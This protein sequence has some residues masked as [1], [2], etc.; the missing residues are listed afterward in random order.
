MNLLKIQTLMVTNKVS[1]LGVGGEKSWRLGHR[2][3]ENI[4]SE[5]RAVLSRLSCVRLFATLRTVARQAPLSMGF[6]RQEN[7]WVPSPSPG[8]LPYRGIQP[9]T[10]MPPA[11]AGGF[12]TTSATW[13]A[14]SD[15][16]RHTKR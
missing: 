7:E 3:E 8:H 11:F 15:A 1:G 2:I 16:W 14:M 10:L 9:G 12:F 5:A 4:W 6:S 13:E